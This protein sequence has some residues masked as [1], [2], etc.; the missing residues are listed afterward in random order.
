MTIIALIP[1]FIIVLVFRAKQIKMA[2]RTGSV[3][4]ML[5]EAVLAIV[6]LTLIGVIYYLVV[7]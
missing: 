7:K 4:A 3:K 5:F 1:L 6:V 2:Y